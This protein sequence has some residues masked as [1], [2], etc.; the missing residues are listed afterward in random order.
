M[1]AIEEIKELGKERQ[2]LIEELSKQRQ[3]LFVIKEASYDEALLDY[4]NSP[5]KEI[6][7]LAVEIL[8]M[9]KENRNL[10]PVEFILEELSMLGH[11]PN[12][13]YDDNGYWAVAYDGYQTVVTEPSDVE[14][15]FL[16]PKK[17]WKNTIREALNVYLDDEEDE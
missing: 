6:D 11:A 13:L 10:L 1:K 9:I 12:L 15:S 7:E 17:L 16:V 8:D 4:T 2:K 14:T 3:K 5:D